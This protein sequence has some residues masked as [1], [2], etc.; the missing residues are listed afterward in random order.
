MLRGPRPKPRHDGTRA[1]ARELPRRTAKFRRKEPS[2]LHRSDPRTALTDADLDAAADAG[3]EARRRA[4]AAGACSRARIRHRRLHATSPRCRRTN[5]DR[6]A[7]AGDDGDELADAFDEIADAGATSRRAGR[8]RRTVRGRDRRPRRAAARAAGR[9]RAHLRPARS[10]AAIMSIAW[11]SAGWSRASGRRRRAADPWL[12]RPDAPRAR[13]RSAGAAHRPLGARLR[14]GARRARGDPDPRRQARRRA[15]GRVALHA[16]ARGGRRRSALEGGAASAASAISPG[17]ASSIAPRPSKPA[18]RPAPEAAARRAARRSSASPRSSTGCA[19]PT[20]SMP[21]TFSSCAPLDAVDTP[22][23]AR[24]RGTVIHGAIGDFTKKY[25]DGLPA[26]PLA[27][28]LALGEQAFRA[29]GGLSRGARV[30]VAAL[31]A[32][33]AL[34]R[35]MGDARRA[36]ARRAACRDRRR[37]SKFRSASAT[38]KLTHARRPHRAAAPTAATRSSTTRPARRRP[39]SRCAPAC[40]R[41]SRSKARSCARRLQGR[42]PP[43]SIAELALCARCAAASRRA[44]RSRSNSRTARAGPARRQGAGA[45]RTDIVARFEDEADALSLAGQPDVE[46]ALRRLRPSGARQGMV[47]AAAKTSE[48]RAANERRAHPRRRARRAARRVRSGASAW[49]AANAGSGKTHVLAQRV[50]RLLLRGTPPAK[51]L[52]LTYTKA[53]AANMANRVFDDARANGRA[54][55]DDA[56]D[57]DDRARSTAAGRCARGARARG[58]CSR[59]RWRRRAG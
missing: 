35:R 29:A 47:G 26:D 3:G 12:S 22:P 25:A 45:A 27:A 49:V 17:R 24:D 39:S 31:P 50:I 10:A 42:S 48:E 52:C 6:A 19:I 11:C 20:R 21:S 57:A 5:G 56:L 32:H 36:N 38:F 15:D 55:D 28:L 53:A 16:A 58:G 4:G 2:T 59:R 18:T 37:A 30:L 40:R 14:A 41:S 8:L 9:A 13:P 43:A 51:I 34:V 23:G 44:K 7:F 46:D 33:R 54:L 1:C